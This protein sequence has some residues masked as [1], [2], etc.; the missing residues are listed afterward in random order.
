MYTIEYLPIAKS[1]MVDIAKYIGVKLENPEAAERLAEKM[2]EA[3]EKLTD[4]PYKCP[5][6]IPVK[7]LR[8][9]Y[10]KL[11]V[12]NYIMFYWVDEDKKRITIARV[13]YT[14]RDY[15]NLL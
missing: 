6:H 11:I 1:D 14:G 2:I 15:E 3:A 10:R 12:Q 13:V 5:V 7:P 8:H 4:M 9:E